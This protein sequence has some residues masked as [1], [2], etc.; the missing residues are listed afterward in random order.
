MK[1][2]TSITAYFQSKHGTGAITIFGPLRMRYR[3]IISL[4]KA[5]AYNMKQEERDLKEEMNNAGRN[6]IIIVAATNEIQNII[7][8]DPIKSIIYLC[9]KGLDDFVILAVNVQLK[10]RHSFFLLCG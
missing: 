1:K 2:C 3:Y 10:S 7:G 4:L 6:G 9:G 8:L 5:I